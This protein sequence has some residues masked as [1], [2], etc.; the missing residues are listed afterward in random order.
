MVY[1]QVLALLLSEFL[2]PSTS[3]MSMPIQSDKYVE[4]FCDQSVAGFIIPLSYNLA[5]ILICAIL[6]FISRK[7]PQNYNETWYIFV[8][9][10]TTSFM[11]LVL[12]PTYFTSFYASN[13]AA[14]LALCMLLNIG[15]TLSCLFFPKV[16]A[17]L[18][19]KESNLQLSGAS[20]F[21]SNVSVAPAMG[22][23]VTSTI[24]AVESWVGRLT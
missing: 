4:L 16:Y 2:W 7:I 9:V 20:T 5:F 8:S 21:I 22:K 24:T 18:Y 15:I 12:L 1:F 11:W 13:K 3:E 14:L 6:G 19:V 17:V 10:S 23:N